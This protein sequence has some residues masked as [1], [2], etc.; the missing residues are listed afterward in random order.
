MLVAEMKRR[1]FITLVGGMA[2]S[3][4]LRPVAARA[5]LQAVPVIGFLGSDSPALS[6]E[7]LRIFRQALSDTGFVEKRNVAIEYRWAEGQNDRLPALAAD[8]VRRRVNVIVVPASTPGALAA[9]RATATIPIVIFTAGNPVALGLVTSLD[10]PGGNVTGATSLGGEL[11]PKRLELL[12][13]L[14]PKATNMALLVNPTNPV[15][16]ESTSNAVQ[17]AAPALGLR[18]Q[19]VRAGA[20]RDFE[21]VFAS[22]VQS[23]TSALVIA[24]DSFFTGRREQLAAL[25]LSHRIPAIYQYR[26]FAAAGGVMSYGGSLAEGFRLVAL[27]TSRILK[28]EKPVE[29]PIQQTTKVELIINIKTAA[30]LGLKFPSSL[31]A[32]ADEVIE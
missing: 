20:E 13:E 21:P 15:L 26:D 4:L 16:A 10:R 6:R 19:I 32:L 9:K 12:H 3:P 25:A 1:A 5:Q 31:L 23:R 22:L 11:A 18:L 7:A 8:L 14:M 2:A 17:A 27:Y 30:A 29:L 24:I 28:G